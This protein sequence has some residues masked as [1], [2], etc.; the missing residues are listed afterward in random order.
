V[1]FQDG[2]FQ[3]KRLENLLALARE[4][5][6]GGSGGDGASSS[7]SSGGSG[8]GLDLSDTAKDALRVLLLD[9]RLRSQVGGC[10]SWGLRE[11]VRGGGGARCPALG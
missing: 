10:G 2:K 5:A 8:G 7:S 11:E 9:D 6:A 3:W 1:L 4:G